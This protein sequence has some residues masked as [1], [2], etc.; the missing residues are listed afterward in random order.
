MEDNFKRLNTKKKLFQFCKNFIF[1]RPLL[2]GCIVLIF[3]FLLFAFFDF[4]V[5]I[6]A[7]KK[8]PT[9]EQKTT[10]LKAQPLNDML[11]VVGTIESKNIVSV[12]APFDGTIQRLYFVS[13]DNIEFGQ[14]LLDMDTTEIE[15]NVRDAQA[16][17]M[18]AARV[19]Q[20]LDDWHNGPEASRAKRGVLTAQLALDE[21]KRKV[22]DTQLLLE[23]GI[24]P[25]LEY[26]AALQQLSSQEIQLTSA[27]EDLSETLKKGNLESQKL[28]ALELEN[29]SEKL[30]K[31]DSA[32][33]D[34][35]LYAAVS[36]VIMPAAISSNGGVGGDTTVG[37]VGQ[38]VSRGQLMYKIANKEALIVIAKVNEIDVN[39]LKPGQSVEIT[40]DAFQASPVRGRLS[41][42]GGQAISSSLSLP[43]SFEIAVEFPELTVEQKKMI[44]VGMSANLSIICYQ[45]EQAIVIPFTA[46]HIE[47]G[48]N[49]VWRQDPKSKQF[50]KI[51]V[52]SERA[53]NTGIEI[54][55]GLQ[56]DDVI[57]TES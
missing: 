40:G 56:E 45:S 29:A 3:I 30:K 24:V 25:R 6:I 17:S 13:G 15:M 8:S 1:T 42:I 50:L 9:N 27:K 37:G 31:L 48:K 12:V 34:K 51:E 43:A 57:L 19:L 11:S 52:K 28:A 46:L 21:A 20:T 10:T 22:A 2:R 35:S 39:R 41:N 26:E 23:R 33:H 53:T 7:S 55:H 47:G 16:T 4:L 36:G 18:K 54:L 38:H 14:L 5:N 32:L 44:R 49:F